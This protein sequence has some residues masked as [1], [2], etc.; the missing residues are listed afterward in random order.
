MTVTVISPGDAVSAKKNLWKSH[1][2][3]SHHFKGSGEV[4]FHG[5]DP[6]N[7]EIFLT[8]YYRKKS[9]TQPLLLY[10]PSPIEPHIHPNDD[11]D[12]ALTEEGTRML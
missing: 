3:F 11:H 2:I 10:A 8:D 5:N 12:H 1:T 6:S 4:R 7:D 9:N